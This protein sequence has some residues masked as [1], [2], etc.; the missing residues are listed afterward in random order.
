MGG[1][2]TPERGGRAEK[3]FDIEAPGVR[4]LKAPEMAR[5]S[6]ERSQRLRAAARGAIDFDAAARRT[7]AW[8]HRP[9]S[10][11]RDEQRIRATVAAVVERV[12]DAVI[13][14]PLED[15]Q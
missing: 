4:A 9:I 14:E 12:T 10:Q 3:Y 1:E 5:L 6:A 13:A 7:G 2:A 8:Y 15:A 11:H